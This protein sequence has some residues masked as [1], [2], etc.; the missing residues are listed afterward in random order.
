MGAPEAA[1]RTPGCPL[2]ALWLLLGPSKII[3]K[4]LVFVTFSSMGTIWGAPWVILAAFESALDGPLRLRTDNEMY[5]S[6]RRQSE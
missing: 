4:P 6:F 5:H 2:G 3:E 1:M